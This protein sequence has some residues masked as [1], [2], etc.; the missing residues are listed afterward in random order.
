M[1]PSSV[2]SQLQRSVSLVQKTNLLATRGSSGTRLSGLGLG[3]RGRRRDIEGGPGSALRSAVQIRVQQ[4]RGINSAAGLLGSVDHILQ[5]R[6]I[7]TFSAGVAPSR[8]TAATTHRS[9]RQRR[10]NREANSEYCIRRRHTCI[11][12][13]FQAETFKLRAITEKIPNGEWS[14]DASTTVA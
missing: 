14:T 2:G 12:L 1:A 4:D 6:V 7:R 3:G 9:H 10:T 5:T 13:L 8:R 11:N